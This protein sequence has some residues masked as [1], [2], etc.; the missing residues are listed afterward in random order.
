MGDIFVFHIDFLVT[1][2]FN[3]SQKNFIILFLNFFQYT[4]VL[5]FKNVLM[6]VAI[7]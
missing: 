3:D 5:F 7:C 1:A 2:S 4:F 6:S